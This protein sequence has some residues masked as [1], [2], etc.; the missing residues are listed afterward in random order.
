M[1]FGTFGRILR[2]MLSKVQKM[3]LMSQE[4]LS[5]GTGQFGVVR[6]HLQLYS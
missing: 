6:K 1:I 2:R 3:R 4:M 5:R